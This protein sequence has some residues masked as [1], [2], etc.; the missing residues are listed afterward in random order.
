[1]LSY[2][3]ISNA[4]YVA[5]IF[6]EQSPASSEKMFF[7]FIFTVG[8]NVLRPILCVRMCGKPSMKQ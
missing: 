7:L 4:A 6:P 8:L 1:M 5:N 2:I 3:C